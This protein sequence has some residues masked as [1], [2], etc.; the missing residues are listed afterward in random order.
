MSV[1]V[2]VW[3]RCGCEKAT[4]G[5]NIKAPCLQCVH[6][7][8]HVEGLGDYQNANGCYCGAGGY[9]AIYFLSGAFSG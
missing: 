5:P 8:I 3:G 9:E 7:Y 2:W 1:W 6:E 4:E